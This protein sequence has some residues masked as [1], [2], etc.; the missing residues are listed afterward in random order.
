MLIVILGAYVT[1]LC[2]W[3][4]IIEYFGSFL[5]IGACVYAPLAALL[6]ADFFFVRRQKI[7]LR[8]AF[9]L[10]GYTCYDYTKGFNIVGL[11]CVAAGI[12]MSL[13]VYNPVSGEIHN[14]TLFYLTPTGFSF[15]GTILLYVALSY[16]PPVRK[17][18]LNDRKD[19]K[20]NI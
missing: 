19:I 18:L 10:K 12:A 4:K 9:G 8:A 13:A 6:F 7:V 11:I 15:I 17:Y 2:I 14:M 16:I 1:L 20:N 3:G 5:T